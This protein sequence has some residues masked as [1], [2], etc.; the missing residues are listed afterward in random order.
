MDKLA[1]LYVNTMNT[2]HYMHDKYAYEAGQMAL[3]DADVHRYIAFGI[4]GLSIAADSL[5]AIKYARVKPIRDEHGIAVDFAVEGSF[6]LRQRRRSLDQIAV[7]VNEY[8]ME[9]LRRHPAYRGAET[10][11]FPPHDN[12]KRGVR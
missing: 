10:H 4:A 8:F 9:A 7:M 3:H 1:E 5:S 2:I 6:P 12:V 11:S